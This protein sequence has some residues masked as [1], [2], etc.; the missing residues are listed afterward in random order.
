VS[1]EKI[2]NLE[3]HETQQKTFLGEAGPVSARILWLRF[4]KK[5]DREGNAPAKP[6]SQCVSLLRGSAGASPSWSPTSANDSASR[7]CATLG[8]ACVLL[9]TLVSHML[10]DEKSKPDK[11]QSEILAARRLA[12]MK[13]HVAAVIIESKEVGFPAKFGEKPIFRYTDPAR[14]YVAA[15]VWKL[16]DQGRPKAI[17][18][19][20]LNPATFGKPCIAY[21]YGSLTDSRFTARWQQMNWSPKGTLY[22]FKAIPE[23]PTPEK[24]AS[25]RLIQLRALARRFSATEVVDQQKCELRLLPQPVDR[26]IPS[27]EDQSDGAVFFFVFGTNPEVVLLI[28]SNGQNWSYA[29]GRLT[30]AQEVVLSLDNSIAWHGDPLEAGVN[31]PF[32]GHLEPIDI[33]GIA[34]EGSETNEQLKSR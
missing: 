19:V 9:G 7:P 10:A 32:T 22:Q 34:K 24:S 6:L 12:L 11:N 16:G 15:S 14:G 23:S 3:K 20:E 17:L 1:P 27:K 31:S 21:E 30:G 2:V 18:A 26:Y 13:D 29:A 33:P 4:S 5:R 8:F 28:E 25:L